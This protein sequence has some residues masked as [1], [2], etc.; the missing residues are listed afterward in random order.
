MRRIKFNSYTQQP[1]ALVKREDGTHGIAIRIGESVSEQW[2]SG[3]TIIFWET[4]EHSDANEGNYEV[5][6]DDLWSLLKS[7]GHLK[8]SKPEEGATQPVNISLE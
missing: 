2:P 4:G 6:N 1:A 3:I 5:V 7:T 8:T